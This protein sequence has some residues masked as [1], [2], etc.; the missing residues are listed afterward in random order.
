MTGRK[1]ELRKLGK[2]SNTKAYYYCPDNSSTNVNLLFA[3]MRTRYQLS[4]SGQTISTIT[5]HFLKER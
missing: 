1:E 2:K 4:V 5:P 3:N